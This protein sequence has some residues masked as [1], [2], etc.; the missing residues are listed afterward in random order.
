MTKT[1][2]L[3]ADMGESFGSWQK[4]DD[5]AL[6][7][8]VTSAN[9]ACGFHAGDWDVM[10]A[11]MQKA[12]EKGVNIGAH[13]GF[14]DLQG[15]GRQRMNFS[16]ASL[17]NLVRYQIGAA[18]AMARAVGGEVKHLKLH[19]ALANMCAEDEAM[20]KACY[21][22]ALS[23]AP[24]LIIMVIAGTAQQR[25]AQA[26]NCKFA[27][28]IFADRAYNDDATLVDRKQPGAVIHDPDAAA[29]RVVQMVKAGA[30][31]A[32]SGQNIPTAIDTICL[33]GD[34]PGAIEIA[35]SVR[36]ALVNEA[37]KIVPLS[38]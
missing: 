16:H 35:K 2:D 9:I 30:I 13:P 7:D 38:K 28:E 21:E 22:A 36:T 15:F 14:P 37:I 26:L 18:Q 17:G 20:A 1:I 34:T 6:L 24:D 3:N 11:T 8:I 33:H 10:A 12:V 27:C 5:S 31:I 23:V 25:A 4:G 29:D 19:G 32:A